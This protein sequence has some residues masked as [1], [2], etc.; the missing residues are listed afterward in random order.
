MD[1][2]QLK[3][4]Y[5]TSGTPLRVLAE[6]V[7]I[8]YEDIH[9][10][11]KSERW[12]EERAAFVERVYNETLEQ[13]KDAL[14][15]IYVQ[16][17][18]GANKLARFVTSHLDEVEMERELPNGS[19]VKRKVMVATAKIRDMAAAIRESRETLKFAMGSP[20]EFLNIVNEETSNEVEI[21]T[22]DSLRKKLASAVEYDRIDS[23]PALDAPIEEEGG[24]DEL[25]S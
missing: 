10:I 3:L 21:K 15:G 6:R 2:S 25:G 14:V 13:S 19:I 1:F 24:E 20:D 22:V 17:L 16:T 11:A 9:A 12:Q 8:P 18:A 23:F 7:N 5:V 4:Q